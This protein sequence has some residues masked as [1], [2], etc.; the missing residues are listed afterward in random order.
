MDKKQEYIKIFRSLANEERLDIILKLYKEGEL[1]ASDIEKN[2]FME[3]ST[4]SHHLNY[5]KS[6][7][8]LDSRKQGRNVY[9][10]VNLNNLTSLYENFLKDLFEIKK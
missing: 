8:I 3:Q 9:Y 5:L 6:V 4:T 10:K 7:G 1:C 2:F